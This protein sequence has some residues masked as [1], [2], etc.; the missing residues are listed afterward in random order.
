M[1]SAETDKVKGQAVQAGGDQ[2]AWNRIGRVGPVT[3]GLHVLE[4][5][6]HGALPG[7]EHALVEI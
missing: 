3:S 4:R 6:W 2:A 1:G 7:R 5:S